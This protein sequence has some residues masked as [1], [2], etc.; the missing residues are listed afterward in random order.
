MFSMAL[1]IVVGSCLTFLLLVFLWVSIRGWGAWVWFRR[2]I[3]LSYCFL[4]LSA[5][6]VGIDFWGYFKYREDKAV[7]KVTFQ[8]IQKQ[9]FQAEMTDLVSR[10]T[11]RFLIR[12]DQWQMDAQILRWSHRLYVLGVRPGYRLERL[13]GRYDAVADELEKPRTVFA[14]SDTRGSM[15]IWSIVKDN[16]RLF[17]WV[18]AI[19]GNAAYM[20]MFDGA[21]YS[22]AIS[23]SG[24]VATPWRSRAIVV[25][26]EVENRI[27]DIKK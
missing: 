14:L 17:P 7:V 2:F 3:F 19:Y 22:V 8:A 13:S 1:I 11:R 16:A 24:L 27:N 4:Y 25:P 5:L 15:D 6:I 20:P 23:S 18:E 21:A 10:K 9:L 26:D 12:G